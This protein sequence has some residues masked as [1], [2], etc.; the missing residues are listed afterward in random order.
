[1]LVTVGNVERYWEKQVYCS[2]ILY[3][4]FFHK[5][6]TALEKTPKNLINKRI[7]A[8]YHKERCHNW[9]IIMDM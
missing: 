1:M 5:P 4:H 8:G 3:A 2:H 6:K 9:A 7:K